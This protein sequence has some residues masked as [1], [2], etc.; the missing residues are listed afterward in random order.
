MICCPYA[1]LTSICPVFPI[2]VTVVH[3]NG[4]GFQPA[5]AVPTTVFAMLLLRKMVAVPISKIGRAPSEINAKTHNDDW[6]IQMLARLLIWTRKVIE[7][8]Q[9]RDFWVR[10][11]CGVLLAF[12]CT[13]GVFCVS[14]N[15]SDL[16][17]SVDKCM[18][19]NRIH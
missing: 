14:S 10:V 4:P 7:I 9:R 11:A 3:E 18:H 15:D 19:K 16:R 12:C 8:K 17:G 6:K 5:T 2:S 13:F 1:A